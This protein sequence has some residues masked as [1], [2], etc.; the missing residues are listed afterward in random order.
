MSRLPHNISTEDLLASLENAEDIDTTEWTNDV[1][2]FL[3]HFKFEQ[4]QYRVRSSLLY[5]LYKLYSKHPITQIEFSLTTSQFIQLYQSYFFLNVKPIKIAKVVHTKDSV[6]KINL[7]ANLAFKRHY[8]GFLRDCR[9][10][11]GKTWVE[12]LIFHEIYR[13]YCID[14]K[15]KNRITYI[16]FIKV[17]KLY[18][19]QRRIGS[20]RAVWFA[21]DNELVSRILTEDMVARVNS[22]RYK[23]SEKTKHKNHVANIGVPNPK[24]EKNG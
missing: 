4:G 8:E 15:I 21:I 18:F 17:G 14:K 23:P 7:T 2:Q 10:K 20:S 19:T 1:P 9:V 13:H 24:K 12:G 22:R 5:K 6:G 3:S 11:K 16:N